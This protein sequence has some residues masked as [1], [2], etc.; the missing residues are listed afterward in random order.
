MLYDLTCLWNVQRKTNQPQTKLIATDNRQV[1]ARGRS[2][3]WVKQAKGSEG[4]EL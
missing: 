1:V 3:G 4:T 2:G